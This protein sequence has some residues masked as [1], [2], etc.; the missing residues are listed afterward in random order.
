MIKLNVEFSAAAAAAGVAA[1][2][3]TIL[4]GNGEGCAAT[5]EITTT[6]TGETIV[7]SAAQLKRHKWTRRRGGEWSLRPSG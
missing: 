4:N 7:V 1:S 2:T 6:A 3:V 5:N